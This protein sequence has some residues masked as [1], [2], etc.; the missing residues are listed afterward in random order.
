MNLLYLKYAVEIERQ[1]SISKAAQNLFVAQPNLSNS[2]KEL[3]NEIGIV[4]FNRTYKGIV[5]THAGREFL[6]YAKSVLESVEKLELMYKIE[7]KE[8]LYLNVVTT[9]SSYISSAVTNCINKFETNKDVRV[10][11]KETT[12]FGVIKDISTD[13]FDVGVYRPD[14]T[15][16]EYFAKLAHSKGL[17]VKLLGC[18][19]YRLLMSASHPLAKVNKIQ[20]NMLSEYIE[21]LYG[22]FKNQEFS[23]YKAR[24]LSGVKLPSKIVYVYDRGSLMDMLRDVN[25]SYLWTTSTYADLLKWFNLVSRECEMPNLMLCEYLVYKKNKKLSKEILEFIDVIEKLYQK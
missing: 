17:E 2:I 9:R 4:I 24:Q 14:N 16:A 20:S 5:V 12:V 25:G 22:D 15:H 19:P 1:G 7:K 18:A 8:T 10:H 11:F 23:Y 13:E 21:V 3:E 6:G